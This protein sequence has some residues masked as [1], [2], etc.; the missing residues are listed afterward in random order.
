MIR[1][2]MLDGT[3]VE[4]D[5][6]DTAASL[7]GRL[8]QLREPA[9]VPTPPPVAPVNVHGVPIPPPPRPAPA[10]EA[11]PKPP[12]PRQL[13]TLEQLAAL[14]VDSTDGRVARKR[15]A[16]VLGVSGNAAYNRLDRL[17]V[18]GLVEK[19]GLKYRLTDRGWQHVSVLRPAHLGSA[20][21]E[22]APEQGALFEPEP[23][24]EPVEDPVERRRRAM[25]AAEVTLTGLMYETLTIVREY[26]DGI[27][28]AGLTREVNARGGTD[29]T[30]GAIGT[31]AHRLTELGLIRRLRH[32]TYAPVSPEDEEDSDG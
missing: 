6:P 14:A 7:M 32:G 25:H 21:V 30:T 22:P 17:I 12:D 20:P 18:A 9:P 11:A 23:Q 8:G 16:E 3:V 26:P 2:T 31:R 5:D 27:S 1:I 29:H 10:E 24:A 15:L 28:V 19:Q 13:K 4:V